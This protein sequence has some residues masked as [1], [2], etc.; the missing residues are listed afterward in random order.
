[1]ISQPMWF[2]RNG[3]VLGAVGQPGVYRKVS[4]APNGK[5]VAVSMTDIASQNT[6]V[7]IYDLR[8]VAPNGSLSTPPIDRVP[9]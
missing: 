2:D 4:L 9:I 5:S 8:M 3:H 6:D 7:W 1:V